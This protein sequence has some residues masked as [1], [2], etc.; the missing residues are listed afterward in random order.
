MLDEHGSVRLAKWPFYLADLVL[1]GIIVFVLYQLGTFE[2]T[3]EMVIVGACLAAAA[4]G[5]WISIIPW[6]REHDGRLHLNESANLKSSV[7]Q[8]KGID[9]TADLIRQSN[10]QWQGIQD[11]SSRTIAAAKEITERMKG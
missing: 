10:A 9:K 1:S 11:A 5:A 2:G 4:V 6:L 3:T 8:I 7:E